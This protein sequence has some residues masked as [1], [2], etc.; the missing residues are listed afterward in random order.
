MQS[1]IQLFPDTCHNAEPVQ[2]IP[3]DARPVSVDFF[4]GSGLATEA[5]KGYFHSAWANDICARKQAVF[6]ANHP[7]STFHPGSIEEVSGT[8][9]PAHSLSWA[10]FPCQD[11]SLAGNMNGLNSERS[12]MVWEWLRI[13]DELNSKPNI[14]VAENV[15]GLVSAK[16]GEHYL[17]LHEALTVRGFKV[18]AVLLDAAHWVPQSR[19]RVFV[20]GVDPKLDL[21][22]FVDTG[23][24]WLHPKVICSVASKAKDWLWWKLPEPTK[25]ATSLEDL[26]DINE[27]MDDPDTVSHHLGLIPDNHWSKIEKAVEKGFCVFPGYK[28]IRNGKQVLEVRTDGLAGCLRTPSGGSSRQQLVIYKDG[29][30]STRLLTIREAASLMGAPSDYNIPGTYNQGYKA[31]GDAVAVPAVQ[32]LA[33][34]L[35]YPMAQQG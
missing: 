34:H 3:V 6:E 35:L 33:Q 25:R 5:L 8:L 19:P 29:Q 14:V 4:A 21:T 30:Y 18:G 13:L 22:G 10:S 23:P 7:E 27:P 16:G 31:M 9:L 1:Q 24:N 17:A 26:I 11:L 32:Y 28:R 12:G 20:I 15:K 2:T